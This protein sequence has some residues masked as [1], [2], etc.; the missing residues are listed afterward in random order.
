MFECN[1]SWSLGILMEQKAII[2]NISMVVF[3]GSGKFISCFIIDCHGRMAARYGQWG[4]AFFSLQQLFTFSMHWWSCLDQLLHWRLE[5]GGLFLLG[6][7]LLISSHF[8]L[9][10]RE[11]KMTMQHQATGLTQYQ[12]SLEVIMRGKRNIWVERYIKNP[13]SLFLRSF[14]QARVY[15]SCFS[16]SFRW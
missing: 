1:F 6:L 4:S 14:Q 9:V 5:N 2:D 3:A 8:I 13:F 11:K 7:C 10:P 15:L 16:S 12:I